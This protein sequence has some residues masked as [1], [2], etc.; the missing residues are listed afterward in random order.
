MPAGGIAPGRP[1]GGTGRRRPARSQ[2]AARPEELVLG[3]SDVNDAADPYKLRLQLT[4]T[5][6]RSPARPRRGTTP[7]STAARNQKPGRL[8]LIQDEPKAPDAPGSLAVFVSP[9]GKAGRPPLNGDADDADL[10][11][12]QGRDADLRL[13][14][15]PRARRTAR[16]PAVTKVDP[17]TKAQVRGQEIRF[18]ARLSDPPV[19]VTKVFRIWEGEDGF[20][21]DLRFAGPES[22]AKLT[23]RL[24]G[25]HGIPIEGEWYTSTFRD[26]FFG[27]ASRAH[28]GHHPD[29]LRRR[30]SMRVTRSGSPTFP[31]ALPGSRISTSPPSSSR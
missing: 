30:T 14:G 6:P 19:E 31:L 8:V 9:V 18:R 23:Y 5:T 4:R 27:Q 7:S 24:I 26:V 11:P 10:A 13:G 3:A 16:G 15:G 28:R 17:A 2:V 21:L 20:E 22:D 1:H 29:R 12:G 25:P